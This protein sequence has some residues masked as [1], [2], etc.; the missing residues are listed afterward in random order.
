MAFHG[1]EHVEALKGD[2]DDGG[3]GDPAQMFAALKGKSDGI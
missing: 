3:P 2:Y 1:I